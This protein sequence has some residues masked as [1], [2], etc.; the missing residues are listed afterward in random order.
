MAA[1]GELASGS[2]ERGLAELAARR[3]SAARGALA[4][5]VAGGAGPEAAEALS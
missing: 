3:W 5:A 2:L 4:E 1:G